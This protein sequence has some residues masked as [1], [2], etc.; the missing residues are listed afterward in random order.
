L[1]VIED[2]QSDFEMLEEQLRRQGIDASCRRVDTG[3]DLTA[4]LDDPAWDAVLTDYNV[5]G[6][7]FQN[8]V[9]LLRGRRPALPIVL[10]SGYMGEDQA[11]ELLKA[12]ITDF[13]LKYRPARLG[14][15]IRRAV[16]EAHE[17][18]ARR[19]AEAA[20]RE[21]EERLRVALEGAELGMLRFDCATGIFHLDARAQRQF[22]LGAEVAF[23]ELRAHV[24]PD[25]VQ[26]IEAVV[27][28]AASP[29]GDAQP[30][31]SEGDGRY[32][33][34]F[35][36]R[37][38]GGGERRLLVRGRVHFGLD[39]DSSTPLERIGIVQDVT[40]GKQGEAAQSLPRQP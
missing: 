22:E 5:P 40:G 33:I 13:V 38:P 16:D 9:A 10:F 18:R 6:M 12:G 20:L 11:A 32:A 1:L 19:A 21:N 30:A 8:T 23:A 17:Q 7:G 39:G 24:H 3:E 37:L 31:D 2:R 28:Q 27:G 15:A 34:E 35:R 36:V 29:D 14:S 4:A 26:A 25:D